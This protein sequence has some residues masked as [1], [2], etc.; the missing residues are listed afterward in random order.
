MYK[1]REK[2]EH[3]SHSRMELAKKQIIGKLTIWPATCSPVI[4]GTDHTLALCPTWCPPAAAVLFVSPSS[5]TFSRHVGI[6]SEPLQICIPNS[7][8][9]K[10]PFH[11]PKNF[12][13]NSALSTLVL[14]SYPELSL[15]TIA[16]GK[17]WWK[18]ISYLFL[19]PVDRNKCTGSTIRDRS[20]ELRSKTQTLEK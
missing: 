19:T 18:S 16:S 2:R 3:V 7:L 10:W 17:G 5:Y 9:S 20:Q 8:F 6:P 13:S 11:A 15:A 4:K 14:C 12:R 1:L